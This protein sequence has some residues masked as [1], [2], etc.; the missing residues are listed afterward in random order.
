MLSDDKAETVVK[1]VKNKIENL[2]LNSGINFGIPF[3]EIE[4]DQIHTCITVL[5][6]DA[7]LKFDVLLDITAVDLF[8]KN[9]RFKI[10]YQLLSSLLKNRVC[11]VTYTNLEVPSI[12]DFYHSAK[13][14]ER[15]VFD[16]FGIWFKNHEG[17]R[18]IL[19]YDEFEG[20]PLRKDYP[21]RGK[22]PR[23]KLRYPEVPN[24]SLDLE[25]VPL[26]D[27]YVSIKKKLHQ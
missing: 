23:I 6:E 1:L 4:S 5:K 9:P 15:E 2:I 10:L 25:R 18:R 19:L 21:V 17:L 12:V 16:M 8:E 14:L 11:V 24:T 3:F 26:A 7:E 27:V 22:Q 13:F 20:H